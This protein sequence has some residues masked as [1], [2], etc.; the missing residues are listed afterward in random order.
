MM[1]MMLLLLRLLA[2]AATAHNDDAGNSEHSAC[3]LD[4]GDNDMDVAFD[5]GTMMSEFC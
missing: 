2:A 1:V 5:V 3:N 4:D